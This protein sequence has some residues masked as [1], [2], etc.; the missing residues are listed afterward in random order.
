MTLL[1]TIKSLYAL[2]GFV[3]LLLYLPQIFKA[4]KD[5]SHGV[6]VSLLSFG[7][8]TIGSLI[9]ALYAW[10]FV[11]DAM[12]TAVSLGNM[13]GS[14]TVCIIVVCSRLSARRDSLPA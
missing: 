7:G 3:A 9:T 4:W 6:S 1:A 12:F 14:G 10:F 5:R 8:W 13:V 11:K 2:N